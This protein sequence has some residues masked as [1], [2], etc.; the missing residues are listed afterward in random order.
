MG[1]TRTDLLEILRRGENS[2]VEF[3][4]DDVRP[5]KIAKAM[6]AML[7]LEGGWILLG[8]EDDGRVSGLTRTEDEAGQWVMNIA[9]NNVRPP[10]VPSWSCMTVEDG[11]VIGL[12]GVPPDGPGKPYRARIGNAWLTFLRKG[13]SS[14]EASREEEGRLWQQAGIVHYEMKA[15][16]GAD[17]ES[18]EQRLLAN[19][20]D[21]ILRREVPAEYTEWSRV[22]SNLG[23]LED[24]G[25]RRAT[26]AGLLLF[27]RN[28]N[29]RLPQAGITAVAFPTAEKGYATIE[30][31]VIRG[32]LVSR[33]SGRG[34]VVEPGVIDRAISFVKRNVG[35]RAWIHGGRRRRRS[36]LPLGAVREAVVNAVAHRDYSIEVA[37]VE[38]SLY[39]DRLEVISPGRLP[40]GITV[41]RMREGMR[42][43][44]NGLVK[45]VLRDYRY[46][47]H[48][49]MGVRNRIILA[50][51]DHNG[52]EVDL[53]EDEQR[54]T[55]RLWKDAPKVRLSPGT[56]TLAS[57]GVASK[58]SG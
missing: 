49:G 45:D 47:E 53:I 34:R 22:L 30:E 12:V 51:R 7:N 57:V 56:D 43:A 10:A 33:M 14:R 35:A 52:T 36:A 41:E 4:R 6:S 29:R 2:F 9:Q 23:I 37:D 25:G 48:F 38:V 18:L 1:I 8:V 11:A 24:V 40:N 21:T 15:V 28:P 42:A 55:V 39:S 20:F 19:Y 3:K 31:E 5:E 27:A 16:P 46:V 58:R 50:M 32:P 26:V 13:A 17:M 44:R 54:F